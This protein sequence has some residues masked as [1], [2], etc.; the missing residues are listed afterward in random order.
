MPDSQYSRWTIATWIWVGMLSVVAL[1]TASQYGDSWDE[2]LRFDAG[3][4]K[5]GYYQAL[6]S[7]DMEG[8]VEKAPRGDN[9]PGFHDLNL[10][11]LRRISPA[12]DFLTGNLFS[13]I[14]GILG[15][16]GTVRLARILGGPAAGFWAGVLLTLLPA[17]YGHMFINPKD[18]PFACGYIWALNFI[19][20]WITSRKAPS[21][22]IVIICGVAIGVA[23][24]SRIGGLLLICYLGLF[25]GL[26]WMLDLWNSGPNGGKDFTFKVMKAQLPRLLT[27]LCI[28]FF[29][30]LLYWPS[31]QL[32]PF[33]GAGETLGKITHYDWPMPVF[34]EGAFIS[35]PDL[36]AYYILKMFL[37][38]VPVITLL[39]FAASIGLSIME[40]RKRWTRPKGRGQSG[41]GLFLIFFSILFPLLYVIV[42]DS[43]LYNGLRHL[44][45]V[46]PSIC[47]VAGWALC[48][49]D[50]L[51]RDRLP[52]LLV[53]LRVAFIAALLLPFASMIRLHPYQY[54]YYN[55]LA[56]GTA[57][58]SRSYELD[59]WGTVYKE[60]AEE[61]YAHLA[62]E[63][64]AFSRPEVVVNMEHVTWLFTPFLPEETSLPITVTRSRPDD[65][66][67]YAAATTWAA[68]QFY[69]GEVI[70]EVTRAG[71]TLGVV[72]DRRDP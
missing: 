44:L 31:G 34:F 69:E 17:W 38:K 24:A 30:L 51:L 16:I 71:A 40:V 5:L 29:I 70:V 50:K 53:P 62:E 18:I 65:D 55:E 54:I 68:D 12:P 60:L 41:L 22:R 14:L 21:W 67:Y 10:A 49:L 58:A 63:R 6:L 13:A 23:M 8:A 36:P 2:K 28:S 3:E 33:S 43:I 57:N 39:L 37:L 9:Y 59:Y 61:F 4:L 26:S 35:A 19:F 47:V 20:Q 27:V 7:G 45:F 56:G 32:R 25:I 72:K 42:R 52:R 11:I 15:V 64:P 1:L 46:L 48:R 66:D